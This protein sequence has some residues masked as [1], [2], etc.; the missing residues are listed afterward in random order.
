MTAIHLRRTSKKNSC[1]ELFIHSV[2][3]CES[4]SDSSPC[5]RQTNR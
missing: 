1:R 5:C 3:N 4:I 2:R